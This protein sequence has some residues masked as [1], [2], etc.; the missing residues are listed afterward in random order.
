[1]ATI[2]A[3]LV[4]AGGT[5][6]AGAIANPENLILGSGNL[7]VTA[8]DLS[9]AGGTS[10][11]VTTR[12]TVAHDTRAYYYVR[13]VDSWGSYGNL[14]V[15]GVGLFDGLRTS[16]VCILANRRAYITY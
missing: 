12:D 1:M 16:H 3:P 14:D 10:V 8:S 13:V 15:D 5:F 2:N 9:V 4:L 7:E 6:S 11:D